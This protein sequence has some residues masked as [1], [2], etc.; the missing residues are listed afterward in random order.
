VLESQ[1]EVMIVMPCGYD[2][3]RTID[4]MTEVASRPGFDDL[5]CARSGRVLAVDGSS[6]FSRPGPRIVHGLEI[7]AEALRGEVGDPPPAGAAYWNQPATSRTA[8]IEPTA[9]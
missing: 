3:A 4:L 6:Y 5:E 9:L 7:L 8:L 1:P 2:L